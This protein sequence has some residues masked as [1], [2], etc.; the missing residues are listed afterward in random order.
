MKAVDLNKE[1]FWYENGVVTRLDMSSG[2]HIRFT[3]V[4]KNY[5]LTVEYPDKGTSKLHVPHDNTYHKFEISGSKGETYK[6][7]IDQEGPPVT[8]P[9]MIVRVS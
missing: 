5:N 6:F 8:V 2:K 4:D 9:Q 3:A 1:E 7:T